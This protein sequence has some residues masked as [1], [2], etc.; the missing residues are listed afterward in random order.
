MSELKPR[1]IVAEFH[2]SAGGRLELISL[3]TLKLMPAGHWAYSQ[4]NVDYCR[5]DKQYIFHKSG[6]GGADVVEVSGI[7][8]ATVGAPKLKEKPCQLVSSDDEPPWRGAKTKVIRARNKTRRLPQLPQ[9][10]TLDPSEDLL[11]WLD[12]NALESDSVYCTECRDDFPG[13]DLCK[14]CWWC[15]KT[16]DY[17]TP[18]ERCSC[19]NRAECDEDED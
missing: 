2:K 18:D 3:Q 14:H 6:G 15:Q 13:E 10:F 16:A 1:E 8:F 7:Y 9:A 4:Y 5:R 17:S 11:D 19:K 12:N